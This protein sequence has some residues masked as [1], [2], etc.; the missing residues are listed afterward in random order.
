MY[1]G[2]IEDFTFWYVLNPILLV[3]GVAGSLEGG[4]LPI[5]NLTEALNYSPIT[6]FP[7]S[8]NS[9][10]Y[11]AHWRVVP[12]GKLL[13]NDVGTYPFANQAVAANAIITKPL[14]ISLMMLC[15]AKASSGGY[16]NKRPVLDG[17]RGT[18]SAHSLSGGTYFVATPGALYTNCLLLDIEDVSGSETNQD[19]YAFQF[20]FTQPLITL[21]DAQAAQNT[22]L[23]KLSS[24]GVLTSSSWSGPQATI[25]SPSSGA[26]PPVVPASSS[27]P[28]SGPQLV[29]GGAFSGQ[30]VG[31]TPLPSVS[32][33][34]PSQAPFGS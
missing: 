12:G 27:S 26:S 8:A 14:S 17:L 28:G 5:I 11:F 16:Y 31:A 3:G 21:S 33:L 6:S 34:N 32:G 24:G 4:L 25:G 29:P 9:N 22:F 20:N 23:S 7:A 13:D 19:Q 1:P 18:L 30:G 15:P 2:G 10:S